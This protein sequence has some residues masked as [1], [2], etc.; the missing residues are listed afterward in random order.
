MA[1]QV[2]VFPTVSL[3][4]FGPLLLL[5]YLRRQT[6]VATVAVIISFII[7]GLPSQVTTRSKR[8]IFATSDLSVRPS[9]VSTLPLREILPYP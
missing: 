2:I 6:V 9:S 5:W 3:I 1:L 8:W 7:A 4:S